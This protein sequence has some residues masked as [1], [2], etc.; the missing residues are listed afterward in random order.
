[1]TT[2]NNNDKNLLKTLSEEF[3]GEEIFGLEFIMDDLCDNIAEESPQRIKPKNV[4]WFGLSDL[5]I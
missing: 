3:Q 4:D 1:M 5:C 2:A